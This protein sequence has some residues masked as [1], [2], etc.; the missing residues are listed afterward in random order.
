MRIGILGTRGVPARYGGFETAAEEIGQRLAEWGHEVVV[1]CRNP[2]QTQTSYHGM[3]LVNLPAVR[4]KSL[5]TISH[6]GLS[7]GPRHH[8]GPTRCCVRL[9]RRERALHP[10]PAAGP[11]SPLLST[12]MGWSGRGRSGGGAASAYYK[13]AERSSIHWAQAVI[14]DSRRHRGLP[15]VRARSHCHLHSRTAHRS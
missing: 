14:A 11:G 13:W 2:G 4:V 12:S 15:D 3:T 9:Q 8:T 10:A 5:E 1:Y 6:T 7:D